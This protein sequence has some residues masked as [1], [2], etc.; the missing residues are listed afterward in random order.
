M[1]VKGR[2]YRTIWADN[3]AVYLIDQNLLPFKFKILKIRS[4]NELCTAIKEMNIR[5]AGAI[6]AAAGYALAL[7]F[8]E[9][10][11]RDLWAKVE[12]ARRQI[13]ATRPTAQNLFAAVARVYNAALAVPDPVKASFREAERI[14]AEDLAACKGI[15]VLGEKL[16][17]NGFGIETHCNA[18]WL[19]FVDYGSA[20]SPLYLAKRRGKKFFVYVD[21]T[22]PRNQGAKLT[23]WELANE[24]ID[25][26][27]IADSAGAHLMAHG[28]INLM[29]VGADRIAANGDVANKIGT[30]EKALCAKAFGIPFYVAAPTATIDLACPRGRDIPIEERSPDEI[31]KQKG[32]GPVF[33]IA[34]PGSMAINPGFDVTPAKYITALIT[35]KGIVKPSPKAI[36]ALLRK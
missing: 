12:S 33:Q 24:E 14:A 4:V 23:A 34:N 9:A 16:I 1:K 11:K 8:R 7:A 18:G 20:L 35:E 15:G 3:K 5:G 36:R 10:P 6:G 13:E 21:E 19:A 2:H 28:K 32:E 26:A 27:I 31:L 17:K 22:R 30:L 29:I 25:H